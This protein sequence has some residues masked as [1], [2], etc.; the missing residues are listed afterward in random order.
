MNQRDGAA[1]VHGRVEAEIH[2]QAGIGE[3]SRIEF[4]NSGVD[5]V[6]DADGVRIES[7]LQGD[8]I[9]RVAVP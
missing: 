7:P 2:F 6:Q 5:F 4:G 1:D 3:W 8:V 9:R